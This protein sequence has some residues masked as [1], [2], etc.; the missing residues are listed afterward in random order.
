MYRLNPALASDRSDGDLLRGGGPREKLLARGPGA[1]DE[2]ELLA[3]LLG[4][5]CPGT[6]VQELAEKLYELLFFSDGRAAI[7][8]LEQCL[9]IKGLGHAKATAVIAGLELGRRMA[10][11][12][13]RPIHCPQD[14]LPH[15]TWLAPLQREHFHVLY[16]DTRRRLIASETVSV[17]TLDAS[18]VHP[19][20][21]FRLAVEKCASAVLVAHNHP[22]GDPEPS[23]EDLALTR[24]LD[25]A[26]RLLGFVLVDHLIIG[27][28]DW[29]SLRRRQLEDESGM[30]LFAA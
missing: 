7:P 22:S 4:K 5:G 23:P 8:T 10:V 26:A 24:R 1:L 16:L 21:V 18:L 9:A 6:P 19:R 28:D 27:G 3:V 15:L 2:Y 17:G 12:R 13:G 25:K 30:E 11:S 29:V 14:A 20:E